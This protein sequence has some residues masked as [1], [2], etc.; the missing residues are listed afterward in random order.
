MTTRKTYI[1]FGPSGRATYR[2]IY[3]EEDLGVEGLNDYKPS[4]YSLSRRTPVSPRTTN[5]SGNYKGTT[6]DELKSECLQSKSLFQ[7]PD[8]AAVDSNIFYSRKPPKPFQW[9]RPSVS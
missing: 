9:L 5:F 4:R 8:F 6:Y 3:E 2:T 1:S 7:D